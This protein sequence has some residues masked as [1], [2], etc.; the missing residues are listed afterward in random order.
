MSHSTL[1]RI[2][3]AHALQPHRVTTFKFATDPD[4]EAKIHDVVGLYAAQGR[5]SRSAMRYVLEWLILRLHGDPRPSGRD[6]IRFGVY[7]RWRLRP[8]FPAGPEELHGA[9]RARPPE[10]GHFV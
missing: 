2:R 5:A 1:H 8:S 4:A 7:R 9:D 6:R 10:P 3:Q